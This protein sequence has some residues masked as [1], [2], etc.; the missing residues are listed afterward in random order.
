M[1]SPIDIPAI[2]WH[3]PLD[4]RKGNYEDCQAW[5]ELCDA[6]DL[7]GARVT[8]SDVLGWRRLDYERTAYRIWIDEG[9]A[10]WIVTTNH[11]GGPDAHSKAQRVEVT[12]C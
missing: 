7:V 11:D 12:R 1:N 8:T 9:E 3:G 4:P 2:Q 5:V 10:V 6:A